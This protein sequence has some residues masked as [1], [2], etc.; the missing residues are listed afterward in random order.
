MQKKGNATETLWGLCRCFSYKPILGDLDWK[1]RPSHGNRAPAPGHARPNP[2]FFLNALDFSSTNNIFESCC[3]SFLFFLK[4]HHFPW[5]FFVFCWGEMVLF[6]WVTNRSQALNT[7]KYRHDVI[8]WNL[9]LPTS[10][11]SICRQSTSGQQFRS[12]EQHRLTSWFTVG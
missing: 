1:L 5:T 4:Q 3:G 8:W 10:R 11:P 2:Q 7:M 12:L 6:L 9:S